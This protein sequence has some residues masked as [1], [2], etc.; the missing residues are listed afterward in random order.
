M[1][2]E[3]CFSADRDQRLRKT[4]SVV[5]LA[6]GRAR[7]RKLEG[8]NLFL[9]LRMHERVKQLLDTRTIF[10]LVRFHS[11]NMSFRNRCHFEE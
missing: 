1:H 11:I 5:H 6:L 4:L 7:T 10:R 9:H 3:C 2:M 8:T